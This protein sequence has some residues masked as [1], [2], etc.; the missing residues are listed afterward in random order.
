MKRLQMKWTRF[1]AALADDLI[2]YSCAV[3]LKK[4]RGYLNAGR[5]MPPADFPEIYLVRM[6]RR[7]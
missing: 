6:V 7:E 5:L 4:S 1:G 3:A 2:E